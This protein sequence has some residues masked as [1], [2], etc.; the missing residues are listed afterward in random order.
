M[1]AYARSSHNFT[2]GSLSA[3]LQSVNKRFLEVFVHLPDSLRPFERSL[4]RWLSKRISRGKVSLSLRFMPEKAQCIE[5][6]IEL[7]KEYKK[8]WEKLH[9]ALELAET[10]SPFEISSLLSEKELFVAA[11]EVFDKDLCQ[12]ALF[13]ICEKVFADFEAAKK[14]EGRVLETEIKDR[15]G[16]LS[17]KIDLIEKRAEYAPQRYRERLQKRLDDFLDKGVEDEERLLKE[18]AFFAEKIDISEEICRFRLHVQ[19]F[20]KILGKN[21]A[22]VGKTLE[23]LLQEMQREIN[24]VAAKSSDIEVS[25]AAVFVKSEVEKIREQIQNVE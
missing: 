18:I 7:A 9:G 16:L 13:E 10:Q 6:N 25:H 22:A 20:Y 1:T 11:E 24:T 21:D 2:L 17:E 12:E 4:S 23:F 8:A 5:A 19:H 3:E 14:E 15:L